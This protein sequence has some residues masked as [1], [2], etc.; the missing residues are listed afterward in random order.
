[1]RRAA[2]PGQLSAAAASSYVQVTATDTVSGLS[3]SRTFNW[4]VPPSSITPAYPPHAGD[5]SY[6]V[7]AGALSVPASGVLGAVYS[8]SGLP[9][10]TALVSPAKHGSVMLGQDGSFSYTAYAGYTG[11]DSFGYD[12]TAGGLVSN[13]GTVTLTVVAAGGGATGGTGG[14][15][16]MGGG[17]M[18][19]MGANPVSLANPGDQVVGEGQ[20]VSLTLQASGPG[21]LYYSA[22]GLPGWASIDPN[23]GLIT[24]TAYDPTARDS[25]G[26]YDTT[27]NVS[28]GHGDS[29]SQSFT[30]TV[31]P[32]SSGPVSPPSAVDDAYTV[33]AGDLSV[34]RERRPRQRHQPHRPADDG[35]D[36]RLARQ[37]R[38]AAEPGRLLRVRRRPRLHRHR[39]LHLH[40]DGGRTDLRRRHGHP[41]T[42]PA[43]PRP[44]LPATPTR[45]TGPPSPS[46]PPAC[47][48]TT[49]TPPG[50]G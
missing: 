22:Y 49:P 12:A 36:S 24:G 25:G 45:S 14:G 50:R 19:G 32:W 5:Q 3:T 21:P 1:M 33:A 16:G 30:W 23:T 27:V 18:G 8:P 39:P 6:T 48:A 20:L 9:A 31:S 37:R 13:A 2:S 34:P 44:P 43:T 47:W 29:A 7:Y 46:R 11:G 26:V 35:G 42:S 4:T 41:G 10:T 15:G 40:R 17:G 38:R 28:D